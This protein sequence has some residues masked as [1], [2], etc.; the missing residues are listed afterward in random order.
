MKLANKLLKVNAY[1]EEF[2][3][4][5]LFNVSLN[6]Q[7]NKSNITSKNNLMKNVFIFILLASLSSC[8]LTP[9]KIIDKTLANITSDEAINYQYNQLTI[10]GTSENDTTFIETFSSASFKKDIDD[11]LLGF[12]YVI[13]DSLIHPYF[14]VPLKTTYHYNGTLL[15]TAMVS[16]MRNTLEENDT[17]KMNKNVFNNVMTGQLPTMIHLLKSNNAEIIGD[18]IV[19][20]QNCYKL[21]DIKDEKAHQLFISKESFLPVM[22]RVITN[23]SQPFIEEYYYKDF[24]STPE[25][26]IP[27]YK[28][29]VIAKAS[30]NTPQDV[31]QGFKVGDKLPNFKLHDLSDNEILMGSTKNI[32]VIYLSMV[33]CGPCQKAIPYVAKI[34]DYFN[35]RDEIDFFVVYPMDLK[36]K[37]I[38]Y[39]STKNI[40]YPI[41]YNSLSE[42]QDRLELITRMNIGSPAV[43]ILDAENSIR[44]IVHGFSTNM[45]DVIIK[46]VREIENID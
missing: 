27:N 32:K 30:Q 17:T 13:Q 36:K 37:L 29:E 4:F 42:E 22:L 43:L 44:H 38:K 23:L 8:T 16:P 45:K 5:L 24:H 41:V 34:N 31:P 21:N 10:Q 19:N 33:N 26:Q 11:K 40:D 7:Q 3:L 1:F 18:T 15:Y 28:S 6:K 20:G 2:I 25:L 12:T 14:H 35:G 46:K 39:A 9:T